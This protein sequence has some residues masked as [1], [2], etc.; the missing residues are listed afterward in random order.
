MYCSHL[1][2]VQAVLKEKEGGVGG[3]ILVVGKAQRGFCV[4]GLAEEAADSTHFDQP[5]HAC[6]HGDIT[7]LD[8]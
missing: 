1:L 5:R 2:L 7:A 4:H 8:K 3:P 6:M